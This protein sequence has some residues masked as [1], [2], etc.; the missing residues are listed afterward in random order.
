MTAIG[1]AGVLRGLPAVVDRLGG[2][3]TALLARFRVPGEAL[4]TDAML[5][6]RLIAR[7]LETAA[8]ELDRPDLGLLLAEQQDTGVFGPLAPALE[9]ART[10]DDALQIA[11]RFLFVRS[12]GVVVEQSDD[13]EA[14]AGVVAIV[15]RTGEAGPAAPQ[16]TDY[17]LGLLHRV[18]VLLYGGRYGLRAVHLPH[19][20]LA[21]VAR[22][23]DWFGADVRFDR[24]EPL[25][26][27]P[28]QL[29]RTAVPGNNPVLREI[30]LDYMASHFGEPGRAVTS[31]VR[32]LLARSLGS[33][34]VSIEAVAR[35]LATPPRTLQRR[36]AAEGTTFETVL[37]EVRRDTAHR[38]VTETD[39]PLSQ[40]AALV[41]FTRQSTLTRAVHR[42]FGC[43]PRA[44]RKAAA[45][46][47]SCGSAG[48][49]QRPVG[50]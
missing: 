43:T 11:T 42:W 48:A 31:Q 44:L 36:L 38:L 14:T 4:D 41:G 40:V 49:A 8:A 33:A 5:P 25:L 37:D 15:L 28:S 39:V 50:W 21:P 27:V 12:P 18:V 35:S 29:L 13:P 26:R 17:G 1:R 3:G 20:P 2:D 47:P 10:F 45:R 7:I 24:P 22:Y 9:N 6:V 34:P 19:A 46:G 16:L 32:M 30:A 23:V